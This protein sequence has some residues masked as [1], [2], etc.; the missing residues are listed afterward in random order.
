MHQSTTVIWTICIGTYWFK[1]NTWNLEGLRTKKSSQ[2]FVSR[3]QAKLNRGSLIIYLSSRGCGFKSRFAHEFFQYMCQ[4]AFLSALI[5]NLNKL[6]RILSNRVNAYTK[7]SGSQWSSTNFYALKKTKAWVPDFFAN[8][9]I[10]KLLTEPFS[11][12]LFLRLPVLGEVLVIVN[13][14]TD[15]CSV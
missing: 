6:A 12:S 5:S 3:P 10:S 8:G 9:Y 15:Y 13:I 11:Q 2:L 4:I 7:K 14:M 1:K